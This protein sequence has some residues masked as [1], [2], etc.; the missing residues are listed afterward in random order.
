LFLNANTTYAGFAPEAR[1]IDPAG[2]STR[3]QEPLATAVFA[4]ALPSPAF[5]ATRLEAPRPVL[6]AGS[7]RIVPVLNGVTF[8][9]P[10]DSAEARTAAPNA[11]APPSAYMSGPPAA[12]GNH[13]GES[14]AAQIRPA[15]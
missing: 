11:A 12:H 5:P 14:A 13:P 6:R 7:T 1:E 15:S 3:P 8:E 2:F 4:A 10:A 9:G